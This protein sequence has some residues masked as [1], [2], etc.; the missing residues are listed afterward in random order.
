MW[1]VEVNFAGRRFTHEV[2]G[3][4]RRLFH[5][6]PRPFSWRPSQLRRAA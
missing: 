3:P 6:S 5:F 1:I 2:H 4:R